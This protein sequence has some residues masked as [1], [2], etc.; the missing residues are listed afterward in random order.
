MQ[1][2]FLACIPECDGLPYLPDVARFE[3]ALGIAA[4]APDTPPLDPLALAQVDQALSDAV[5]FQPHP[6]VTL[7]HLGFPADQITDAVMS[8]DENAI[9]SVDLQ[10]G[11]IWLVVHRGQE[12]IAAE[13]VASQTYAFLSHLFA[14]EELGVVLDLAIPDTATILARQFACQRLLSF[15]LPVQ[16]SVTVSSR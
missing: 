6:S 16:L 14:G 11:P 13:R 9:A 3:W 4:H 10:S 7:L 1:A 12:G 5:R 8:G 15:S 2:F